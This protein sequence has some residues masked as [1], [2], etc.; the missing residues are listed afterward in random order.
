M[1]QGDFGL[2]LFS[3]TLPQTTPRQE[4]L[5]FEMCDANKDTYEQRRSSIQVVELELKDGWLTCDRDKPT[6]ILV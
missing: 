5:W 3:T 6:R 1:A 2:H 4:F